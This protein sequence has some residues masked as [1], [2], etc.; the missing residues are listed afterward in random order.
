MSDGW[1]NTRSRTLVNFLVYCP[2][3][4]MFLKSLD[5][6]DIPKT[7]EILFNVFDNIVQE[8]GP[9]NIV[10]FITDNA[11]NY[12]VAGD[13]LFQK[14]RT[15][16]WSPC[17][18]H[19]VNLMLQDLNEMHD[20]KS[21]IDQCQE[22]TKFIYNHAY[23]LSL[24]RKF[25]KG[26]ELI[27]P[28]QTRFATNVLTVQS[29]VKQITPL[30]QMFTSEEWA[31]YP[32]AHKRNA[33]LVVDILLKVCVP[34][35]KVLRLADSED[36][37][38]IKYLC[39]AMDKAKEAIQDNLKGKKKLYMS[40]WKIIDKRW[41]GQLH[42]HLHAPTY[43]LNPAI[44]FSPTFK[45]D[46]E[47]M[48]G[49]LDCINVLVA[50]SREQDVVH[51]ELD[52]YD[53]CFRNMG[54]PATVRARTTMRPDL[55]WNRE[56]EKSLARKHTSQFDPISLQNFDD[57]EPWIEEEPATIFDD[58]DHECFNLEAEATEGFVNEGESATAGAEYVDDP[59]MCTE[60]FHVLQSLGLFLYHGKSID[61]LFLLQMRQGQMA[62][63]CLRMEEE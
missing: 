39:E 35:V 30:R 40:I 47:V 63:S 31:A 33:S 7:V 54:Q 59:N 23:V 13:L 62:A 44:R 49:L 34:L 41:T 10:Q 51:N 58:E 32:H 57:L 2:K 60:V 11:A 53:S 55:W 20:M 36:R 1:T 17:A 27:R 15:F 22:V 4:T 37:P 5:L 24:M 9:A 25:T 56:L 21:A 46:R 29:V 26:V 6:S 8:V 12:R 45:K 48:H 19:C 43:Y 42:Q 52:L 14:Y 61:H 38:S 28:A 50:D 16:N 3:G 18:T